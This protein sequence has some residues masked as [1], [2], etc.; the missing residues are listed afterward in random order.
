MCVFCIYILTQWSFFHV[1]LTDTAVNA[2]K[3]Q[4]FSASSVFL[5]RKHL[6]APTSL[7]LAKVEYAKKQDFSAS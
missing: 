2:A 4:D 3:K 5:I 6:L 7:S 1:W